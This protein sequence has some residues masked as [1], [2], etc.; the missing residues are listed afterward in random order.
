MA[1]RCELRPRPEQLM[2]R[3]VSVVFIEYFVLASGK[4]CTGRGIDEGKSLRYVGME[5]LED[6]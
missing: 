1:W 5:L 4:F 2:C 3:S 6:K